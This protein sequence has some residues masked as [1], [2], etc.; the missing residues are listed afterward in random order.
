MRRTVKHLIQIFVVIAGFGLSA[1]FS[2]AAVS[3]NKAY[4]NSSYQVLS[5]SFLTL[6]LNDFPFDREFPTK[7]P[8]VRAE[9]RLATP[10]GDLLVLEKISSSWGTMYT[11]DSLNYQGDPRWFPAI[12]GSQVASHLGFFQTSNTAMLGP[13]AEYANHAISKINRSLGR[14]DHIHIRFRETG[15]E[16]LDGAEYLVDFRERVLPIAESGH[17]ATHDLSYHFASI[18]YP[19]YVLKIADTRIDLTLGFEKWVHAERQQQALPELQFLA[20][21][22]EGLIDQRVKRIDSSSGSLGYLLA[23]FKLRKT[24]GD[25]NDGQQYVIDQLFKPN[26]SAVEEIRDL[27]MKRIQTT[28]GFPTADRAKAKNLVN[29][30]FLTVQD[31]R[32][33]QKAEVKFADVLA[34]IYARISLWQKTLQD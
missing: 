10:Q 15:E 21:V 25:M 5:E 30:Y 34:E 19:E 9:A 13:T 12:V 24:D 31:A 22:A 6:T 16:P 7:H 14:L 27:L 28:P 1:S 17:Y 8:T 26:T 3:C 2:S 4:Q 11:P 33:R 18:L 29:Q 20:K 32:F 23:L